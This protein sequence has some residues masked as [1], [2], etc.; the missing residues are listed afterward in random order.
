M[1]VLLWHGWLLEGSGSNVYTAR[2][3]QTLRRLGH[4]VLLLCQEAHPELVP[5]VDAYGTVDAAG[6][7]LD[8]SGPGEPGHGRVTLLRPEIGPILPVFVWDE[9]EGFD[10]RRFVDLDDADLDRYL[11]ANVAALRAAAAWHRPRGLDRRPRRPRR[12]DRPAGPRRGAVRGQG[13]RQRPR[14][15]HP[16]PGPLPRAGSGGPGGGDGR[17]GG[18]RRR[19]G[20]GRRARPVAGR[21]DHRR[22]ARG[23]RGD[24]S[25]G[26]PTR[27]P[28]TDGRPPDRRARCRGARAPSCADRNPRA[29]P[30]RHPREAVRAASQG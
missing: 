3:A 19:P 4:D 9:Y 30:C 25:A 23:R 1:R 22:A 14:V 24:V 10:V 7:H 20:P 5:Y 27:R 16:S 15:R 21:P 2:S 29:H 18:E 8:A 11:A 28:A 12:R 26:V 6:V 13:P 17:G